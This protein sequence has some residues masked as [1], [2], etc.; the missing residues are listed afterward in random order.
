MD[1][2][3]TIDMLLNAGVLH[4]EI[5]RRAWA[6]GQPVFGSSA[7]ILGDPGRRDVRSA[8]GGF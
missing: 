1:G 8:E 6:A 2:G 4:D 5:A 3:K 7:N